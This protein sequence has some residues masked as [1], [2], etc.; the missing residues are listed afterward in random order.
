[1]QPRILSWIGTL[2]LALLS[3]SSVSEA[4]KK[5]K[6]GRLSKPLLFEAPQCGEQRPDFLSAG[7][8]QEIV[9]G[10]KGLPKTV[11]VAREAQVWVEGKTGTGA[12]VRLYA[13]QNFLHP[14]TREFGRVICGQTPVDFQQRYSLVAPTLIDASPE[15]KVGNSL[16][17][18]QVIAN[19]G[20]YS[21]WNRRSPTLTRSTNLEDLLRD[22]S[23]TAK[24]FQTGPREYE[25]VVQRDVA[26]VTQTLSVRYEAIR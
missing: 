16:W 12:P 17:Q 26:G 3:V 5:P 20:Q 6:P 15:R 7:S 2:S 21:V 25:I 1:M 8:R 9:G 19:S 13:V 14:E 11:L 22:Q 18:F 23:S 4:V 24:I 10:S